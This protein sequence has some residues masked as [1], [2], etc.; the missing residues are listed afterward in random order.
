VAKS[1]GRCRL[2]R[3][4]EPLTVSQ[5][6]CRHAVGMLALPHGTYS[7]QKYSREAA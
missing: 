3:L 1:D 7:S 5:G 4:G 6:Y 2:T